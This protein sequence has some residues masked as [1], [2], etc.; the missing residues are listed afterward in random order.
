[1][2]ERVTRP[3]FDLE[4]YRLP[5]TQPKTMSEY[6]GPAFKAAGQMAKELA[7]DDLYVGSSV[8]GG[9]GAGERALNYLGRGAISKLP[10]LANAGKMIAKSS[11]G[12]LGPLGGLALLLQDGTGNIPNDEELYSLVTD[13]INSVR[14]G[15]SNY[16]N[17]EGELFEQNIDIETYPDQNE[18]DMR[19]ADETDIERLALSNLNKKFGPFP[20]NEQDLSLP[21]KQTMSAVKSYFD[22]KKSGT[23]NKKPEFQRTMGEALSQHFFDRK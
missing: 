16:E 17:R 19:Y 15:L 2:N 6:Y 7:M 3:P 21:Q 18:G 20:E 1:M 12:S 4:Q 23:L 10:L 11:L 5:T 9:A 8:L 13:E 22:A 14:K